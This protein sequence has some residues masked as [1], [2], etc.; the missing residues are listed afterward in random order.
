MKRNRAFTLVELLVVIGII[1]VLISLLL[2]A[3]NGARKAADRTKCLA[4]LQQIGSAYF[5]Y[6]NDHKGAWPM[7]RHQY[8]VPAETAAGGIKERRWHDFISGYVLG[9]GNELNPQG[10]TA[11]QADIGLPRVKDGNNILWGCPSWRRFIGSGA[12][13]VHPG[14]T[15]NY[16]PFA[17]ND[18][19]PDGTV[20]QHLTQ[21][22]NIEGHKKKYFPTGSTHPALIDGEFY[23]QTQWKR[24]AERALVF[25]NIHP[26]LN[27]SLAWIV[28]WPFLPEG[29]LA[30]FPNEPIA[31][32]WTLDFNRHG[33]RST[34]NQPTDP[35]MNMLFA[36]GH[37]GFV[38]C[39]EAF[40][41]I[42][43][44]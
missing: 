8:Y 43:G 11:T 2:P 5:M 23:T 32:S 19:K 22:R 31:A 42:R 41:A 12:A 27:I 44:R 28:E 26:N 14:Y 18:L 1:A 20:N 25:D 36:D 9:K 30:A 4:A 33:K 29:T 21:Y 10:L 34:G 37:A 24:A 39:R 40:R 17:P 3:L 35:S 38:S 6:A 13:N 16:Y 15:Q 7:Q